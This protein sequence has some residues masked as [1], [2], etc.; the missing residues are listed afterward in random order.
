M[1]YAKICRQSIIFIRKSADTLSEIF[2]VSRAGKPSENAIFMEA[3]YELEI[4]HTLSKI[5]FARGT[6]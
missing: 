4:R 3:C 1:K 5:Y 6:L 2:L